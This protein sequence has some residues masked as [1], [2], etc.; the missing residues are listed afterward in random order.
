MKTAAVILLTALAVAPAAAQTPAEESRAT[1]P[2][3][4]TAPVPAADAIVSLDR[5]RRGLQA[6]PSVDF[7]RTVREG[8]T[9]FYVEVFGRLPP[10]E[11]LFDGFDLSFGPTIGGGPTH[12]DFLAMVTP[13]D[14]SSANVWPALDT[15]VGAAVFQGVSYAARKTAAKVAAASRARRQRLLRERIQWELD[16]IEKAAAEKATAEKASKP[17]DGR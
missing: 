1:R 15:L 7:D 17:P 11:T 12:A 5:V 10:L 8:G 13:R 3:Q 14:L 4:P 16:Q 6:T 9:H 2:A